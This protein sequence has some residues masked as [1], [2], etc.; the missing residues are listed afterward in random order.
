MPQRAVT[1]SGCRK[2]SGTEHQKLSQTDTA[3]T[4]VVIAAVKG[5]KGQHGVGLTV[6]EEIVKKA[7]KDGIVVECISTHLQNARISIKST[8]VAFVV[9]YAPTEDAT[10]GDKAK[11]YMAALNSTAKPVPAREHV[12]VLTDA[13]AKTGKRREGGGKTDRKVLGA[14]RRDVLNENGK[15]LLGFAEDNKLALLNTF[16]S[17]PKRGV[18]FTF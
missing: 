1:S 12:L 9:A 5:R 15:Q 14:Y 11:Y 16:Y 7:G 10:E 3:S 8:F 18:S 2:P 17:T 4:S 13:N 6:K